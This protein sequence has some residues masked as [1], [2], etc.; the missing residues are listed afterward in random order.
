MKY[1]WSKLDTTE[2][3]CEKVNLKND[4]P[5]F[6]MFRPICVKQVVNNAYEIIY[7]CYVSGIFIFHL[8]FN[9]RLSFELITK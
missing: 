1:R 4:G 3:D 6:F 7:V 2:T 9:P 5:T 8:I